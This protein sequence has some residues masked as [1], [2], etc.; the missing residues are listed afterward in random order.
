MRLWVRPD[1]LAKLN[2]TIPEIINAVQT[3]NTVNPA[4]QVG[5]QPVPSGQEFTYAVRAQGRLVTEEDFG[6]V[7]LRA[8]PDG[9]IV[10]VSDVARIELGAQTYSMEGRLN[11]KPAALIALYQ[12]PGANA[13]DAAN[14]AKALMEKIKK[15]FPPDLDYVIAL[16]TTLA[17]TEGIKEIQHTLFEALVLVI[18][19]V[20]VF[21]QGWRATLIPLL[22]VPVSLVGTFMLL[23]GCSAFRST[24]CR[25]SGWSWPSA[26]SSMTPSWWSRPSST[27]SNKACR[28][29]MRH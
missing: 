18:I 27:T 25:C 4:G 8:N 6:K 26:S 23:S 5:A 29:R 24:R 13:L 7:V 16:D 20:F 28:P 17:V 10:R 1:V 15:G 3:Q 14:G 11:G 21:L 9:S 2:I 12:V 22:A 19:V